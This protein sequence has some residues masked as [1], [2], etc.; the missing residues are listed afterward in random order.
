MSDLTREEVDSWQDVSG[1]F[2]W[3]LTEERYYR[4]KDSWLTLEARV[5]EQDREIQSLRGSEEHE[6]EK[7]VEA[8]RELKET[9]KQVAR[10]QDYLRWQ[11]ARHRDDTLFG[12]LIYLICHEIARKK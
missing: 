9:R 12:S 2:H 8:I 4:L 11:D 3:R 5:R 6:R 10:Y 7:H 1:S